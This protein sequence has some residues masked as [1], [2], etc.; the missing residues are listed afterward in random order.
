MI[1]VDDIGTVV[2]PLIVYGQI[3]GGLAQG[4]A[5]ALYEHL[6]WDEEGQPLTAT[7]QD[8]AVPTAHMVPDFEL[9]L[10][11]TQV[12]VQPARRQGR[13]RV[14]LRERAAGDHQRGA[15]CAGA[16]RRHRDRDAVH[17]GQGLARP[18][19]AGATS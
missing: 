9:D 11:I 1:V 18:P 10:T 4:V 13:R 7:L 2:N 15:G 19:S 6:E 17:L 3:A 8:Y 16:A 12:A 14:R 5:E